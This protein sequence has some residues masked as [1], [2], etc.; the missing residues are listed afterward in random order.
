MKRELA[1]GV[2]CGG[3][4]GTHVHRQQPYVRAPE[5]DMRGGLG[6]AMGGT[7]GR[8]TCMEPRCKMGKMGTGKMGTKGR[9]RSEQKVHGPANKNMMP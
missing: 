9:G 5:G 8:D 3:G 4:W 2:V 6:E 7:L 1:C